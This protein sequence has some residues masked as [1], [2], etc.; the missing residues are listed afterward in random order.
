MSKAYKYYCVYR[1]ACPG[2]IPRG[3]VN[4]QNLDPNEFVAEIG[5]GAYSVITYDRRLT[6]KELYDFELVACRTD[7][8]G[9]D[10]HDTEQTV[11]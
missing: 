9:T 2:A 1:P 10:E 6:E 7:A 11:G 4:I 8:E 3:V 5:K